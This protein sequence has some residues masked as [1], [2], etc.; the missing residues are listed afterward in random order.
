MLCLTLNKGNLFGEV[1][2]FTN[3]FLFLLALVSEGLTWIEA[4]RFML[5]HPVEKIQ[6]SSEWDKTNRFQDMTKT[7][8]LFHWAF[9][10]PADHTKIAPRA[11]SLRSVFRVCGKSSLDQDYLFWNAADCAS[12]RASAQAHGVDTVHG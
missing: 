11:R 6:L 9:L 3:R 2:I 1:W 4:L 12:L 8:M 5:M 10:L 7:Q